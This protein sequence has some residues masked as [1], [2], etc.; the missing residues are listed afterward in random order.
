MK[1]SVDKPRPRWTR[2][3]RRAQTVC[4]EQTGQRMRTVR[5]ILLA[6]LVVLALAVWALPVTALPDAMPFGLQS[7]ACLL[8]DAATGTVILSKNESQRLAPASITKVM[9]LLLTFESI[10]DGLFALDTPVQ[11]SQNA[12]GMGGSQAF[13]GGG[14]SYSVS[15]LIRTVVICSANDSAMAL[16]ELGSGTEEAFVQKMNERAAAL[17]MTN[18][19]FA[20]PHG[21]PAADHYSTAMDIALMSC[22]LLKHDAYF[23]Y[24][25]IWLDELVHP[26]GRTTTITNTNRLI[27]Y[28]EGADGVKTGFTSDAMYCLSAS[29]QRNGQRFIAV[30]LGAS[31]SNLRFAEVQKLLD[32]GFAQYASPQLAAKGAPVCRLPVTGGRE[33]DVGVSVGQDFSMLMKRGE[34]RDVQ[35]Q[36]YL[37]ETLRA[38]IAEGQTVGEMVF[39]LNGLE[40][41]RVPLVADK[42]ILRMT[43]WYSFGE[44]YRRLVIGAASK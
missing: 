8:M 21:L 31:T 27:R 38:P 29:A 36:N 22:E 19:H 17:G 39:T 37:P 43:Y 34:E 13:L 42:Q 33:K 30:I 1:I 20:N 15:D 35:S 18:T 10:A 6:W 40:L 11:I 4:G 26:D 5:G 9:T 23:T 44:I 41:G 32:Y 7:R 14:L 25:R 16:A 24:S 3:K 12:A 28:Y 2:I